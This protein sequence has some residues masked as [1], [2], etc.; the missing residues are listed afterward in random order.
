MTAADGAPVHE[1]PLARERREIVPVLMVITDESVASRGLLVERLERVLAQARPRTVL[2]QLRD[3]TLTV[4]ARRALGARL[5]ALCTRHDQWLAVNDRVDLACI[6]GADGVHLG[7]HSVAP[8]DART[9]LPYAFVSHACHDFETLDVVG[10]DAAVLSPVVA[11]RKGRAPLGIAALRRARE[12]LDSRR[13]T[14]LLYALGGVDASSA[15]AC[16]QSGATGV[17]VIG[18]ALDGRDPAPLLQALGIDA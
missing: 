7:E 13:S 4:R 6:L 12:L 11:P 2:V 18:A 16:V 10:S 15:S 8:A 3:P 14:T 17:A 5:R 9:L 1:T